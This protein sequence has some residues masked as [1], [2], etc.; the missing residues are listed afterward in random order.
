MPKPKRTTKARATGRP[1][2]RDPPEVIVDFLFDHGLFHV[3]VANVSDVA[4]FQVSVEFDPAFRGLGGE[5]EVSSLPLFRGIEFLAPRKRIET[6]LD[7]SSAYF[8]RREPRR[9]SAVVSY[10]DARQRGYTR[11]IVHDL[12]IYEDVSYVVS[13]STADAPVHA[14]S[15]LDRTTPIT[16]E[17]RHGSS[18]R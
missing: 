4:A 10:R 1:D 16:G 17:G 2:E 15:A 6:F 14:G 3:A 12:S 13:R 5:R 18:Q 9:I 11:R 7:S 8:D